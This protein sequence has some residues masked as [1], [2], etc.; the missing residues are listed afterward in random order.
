MEIKKYTSLAIKDKLN[1][2]VSILIKYDQNIKHCFIVI[3]Q[4][5]FVTTD[6]LGIYL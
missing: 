6:I 2:F 4:I 5:K 3:V 1:L